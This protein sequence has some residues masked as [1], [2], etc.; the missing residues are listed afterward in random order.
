MTREQI[1]QYI[2]EGYNILKNGNPYKVEGSLWDYLDN[3]DENDRSVL[4]LK[5]VATWPDELIAQIHPN[6]KEFDP[7]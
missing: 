7:K 4:D 2:D 5:E 1:Q 3:L 6:Q